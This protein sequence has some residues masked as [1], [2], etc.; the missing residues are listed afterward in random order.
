M[1]TERVEQA[2]SDLGLGGRSPDATDR[3]VVADRQQAVVVKISQ[4]HGGRPVDDVRRALRAALADEDLPLPGGSWLDDASAGIAAGRQ[5]LVGGV[6]EQTPAGDDVPIENRDELPFKADPT[7]EHIP[8]G[9][10]MSFRVDDPAANTPPP[11]E[12]GSP[13]ED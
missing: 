8:P 7:V 9:T 6:V 13:S 5:F 12:M 3:A 11:S 2:R 4:S 1:G 10:R